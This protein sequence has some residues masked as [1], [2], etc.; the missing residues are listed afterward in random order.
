[1]H[2]I[3]SHFFSVT[4]KRQSS[5]DEKSLFQSLRHLRKADKLCDMTLL[6]ADG[7]SVMCHSIVAATNSPYIGDY[8]RKNK[9]EITIKTANQ[10]ILQTIV[11]YFYTGR[12]KITIDNIKG[13]ILSVKLLAL[14]TVLF[15]CIKVLD[16]TLNIGNW[17]GIF[18][19][20]MEHKLSFLYEVCR[21]FVARNFDLFASQ[22]D[23]AELDIRF[24]VEILE[25]DCV[26]TANEDSILIAVIRWFRLNSEAGVD[27][28]IK[29]ASRLLKCI[30]FQHCTFP[31]ILHVLLRDVSHLDR[32]VSQLLNEQ[33]LIKL[34]HNAAKTD[35]DGDAL[36]L[37]EERVFDNVSNN[38]YVLVIN[39]MCFGSKIFEKC[40]LMEQIIL[41]IVEGI[42]SPKEIGYFL[43]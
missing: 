15:R 10:E 40:N 30:K 21:D 20:A 41:S 34:I 16:H 11:D 6:D 23:F 7:N 28:D 12:I 4:A 22:N 36:L 9:Y 1:M 14:D 18:S 38:H 27:I 3:F 8:V 25:N 26:N 39:I 24:L 31:A 5:L 42:W 37:D 32:D 29:S 2:I 19:F 33:C 35:M 17:K 43:I 13:L